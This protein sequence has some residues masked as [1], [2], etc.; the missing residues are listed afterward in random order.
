MYNFPVFCN[1]VFLLLHILILQGLLMSLSGIINLTKIL[2]EIIKLSMMNPLIQ[3]SK[4]T[5][6]YNE[7]PLRK[8][9]RFMIYSTKI[10]R[11]ASTI[12]NF[13]VKIIDISKIFS[14]NA[15]VI[16]RFF[17][18]L[19]QTNSTKVA[20]IINSLFWMFKFV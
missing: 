3:N 20:L 15:L 17:H 11:R 1:M 5:A 10:I 7:F 2:F 19:Y 6:K 12:I 9:V 14:C 4:L 8:C 16:I 18:F 13:A